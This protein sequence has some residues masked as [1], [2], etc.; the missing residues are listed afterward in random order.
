MAISKSTVI[1]KKVNVPEQLQEIPE[2]KCRKCECPPIINL[3]NS[4]EEAVIAVNNIHLRPGETHTT[5][6]KIDNTYHCVV[7]IGNVNPGKGHLIL[8]DT[9][10]DESISDQINNIV[11]KTTKTSKDVEKILSNVSYISEQL[12]NAKNDIQIHTSQ[13]EQLS[14]EQINIKNNIQNLQAAVEKIDII[15]NQL[16]NYKQITD[17][18]INELRQTILDISTR[19]VDTSI[20]DALNT[21]V[22]NYIVTNNQ[23]VTDISTR[24]AKNEIDIQD[25]SSRTQTKISPI[26]DAS[27]ASLF[28]DQYLLNL[29]CY[30]EYG[31]VDINGSKPVYNTYKTG[32][33]VILNAITSD[34]CEF[35]GWY[36]N[37]E[38]IS[39]DANLEISFANED[40]NVNAT[41]GNFPEIL[42]NGYSALFNKLCL[43]TVNAKPAVV[44]PDYEIDLSGITFN[45]T[46]TKDT[47][48]ARKGETAHITIDMSGVKPEP[49]RLKFINFK[50]DGI[51]S[52]SSTI[53]YTITKDTEF[54]AYFNENVCEVYVNENDPS[55]GKVYGG[56][57][58]PKTTTQRIGAIPNEGYVVKDWTVNGVNGQHVGEYYFEEKIYTDMVYTA[59]FKAENK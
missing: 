13:I 25:I 54:K 10:N 57:F 18:S 8:T 16:N 45:V 33:S 28:E 23:A 15:Q 48:F 56:A 26:S 42:E 19:I 14:A 38:L 37:G 52:T 40:I 36:K 22:D 17:A 47:S 34:N 29:C 58:V 27:I 53:D 12:E 1:N 11:L 5:F 6:Y 39:T 43:I 50:Y 20:V 49:E 32:D 9:G 51:T 4:F 55:L 44:F 7:G 41:D 59:N 21:K 24:V 31:R 30:C 3:Y 46:G 2:S 35:A